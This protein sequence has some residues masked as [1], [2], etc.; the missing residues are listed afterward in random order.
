M[1]VSEQL[2]SYNLAMPC[3]LAI[4][5]YNLSHPDVHSHFLMEFEAVWDSQPFL[6]ASCHPCMA[7]EHVLPE[8]KQS[9]LYLKL[10][11][12]SSLTALQSFYY[13]S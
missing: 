10:S 2:V 11:K 1:L 5:R 8:D 4:H 13:P 12:I 6:P 3:M 7:N 9:N